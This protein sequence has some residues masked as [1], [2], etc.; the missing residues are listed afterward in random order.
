MKSAVNFL[1]SKY[2]YQIVNLDEMEYKC[3]LNLEKNVKYLYIL[4]LIIH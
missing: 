1:Q 4:M 2:F 3:I